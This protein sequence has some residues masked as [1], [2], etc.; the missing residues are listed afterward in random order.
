[1]NLQPGDIIKRSEQGGTTLWINQR[2]LADVCEVSESYMWKVRSNY[3]KS[4]PP[5]QRRL[6]I[7]PDSGHSWRWANINGFFYYA[8]E[9]IPNR[10]PKFY[11]DQL[12]SKSDLLRLIDNMQARTVS[13]I[14]EQ[15]KKDIVDRVNEFFNNDD[16]QYFRYTSDPAFSEE[17]ARE[18]AEAKAWCSMISTYTDGGRYK[19]LGIKRNED[20]Y[21]LCTTIIQNKNLEGLK[22]NTSK[23]LRKKIHFYPELNEVQ[24]RE[25]L[26]SRKYGNSNARK[27][28]KFKLVDTVTGEELPFD[29]HEAIMFNL[30]MAPG[31]P[32]KEDLLP[33][34]EDYKTE[35]ADFTTDAPIAYR[36]FTQY[37]SRFDNQLKTAKARHGQEYYSKNFLTY[38]PSEHLQYAHSL[39]AGDGSATVA[40]KYNDKDGLCRRMNLYVILISDVASRYIAGWAPARE[41]LHNETPQMT[42]QAVKM[43][44]E[45]GGYQTMFEIVTDNHGAFTGA[46]SKQ[47]LNSVFNK[48]RTIKAHNSQANPAET[49]F[50]LFKKTLKRFDNFLRT[51]WIAGINNQANPDFI[52]NNEMLPT[53]DEAILQL[54]KIINDYNNKKLRDGSTP[55]QRFERK[56]PDAKPM[57]ERQLRSVFGY[58]TAVEITRMR[59]FVDVWKADR[60]YKFEIP[61]YYNGMA[62]QIAKA[63]GYKPDAKLKVVWSQD[64]ADLYTLDGRFLCTCEPTKKAVQSQAESDE[65][66]DYAIG[67]HEKRKRQ[68]IDQADNFEKSVAEAGDLLRAGILE[69]YSV[70]IT[71]SSFS[72][73][74]YNGEMESGLNHNEP[75]AWRVKNDFENEKESDQ[76]QDKRDGYSP[77]SAAIDKL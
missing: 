16:V 15:I 25:Y 43:A 71:D 12:P 47:L 39:F 72:K 26:I 31:Q 58:H 41:G 28:G 57:D 38:V 5:S 64:A 1:M 77:E 44:I 50:R 27:V 35:L 29:I 46:E 2:L 9:R 53:Y 62:E 61:G 34:W 74:K 55:A 10:S 17:K 8:L 70:A 24:Q 30:Y 67:H 59:G 65:K 73:E 3:K 69:P 42:E 48:V 60:L 63:T 52:P 37:C 6:N 4:I 75:A 20:F 32:Q 40:Y 21:K 13:E 56:H 36:T 45:S 49:Q 54:Q 51:S 23:S 66:T 68:Q 22:V 19:R 7:L 11:R 76:K 33:L 14:N 18:L